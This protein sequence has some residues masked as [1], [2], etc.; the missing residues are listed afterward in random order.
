MLKK[1]CSECRG[2]W[3]HLSRCPLLQRAIRPVCP[4]CGRASNVTIAGED[5]QVYEVTCEVC[6]LP[7]FVEVH[8]QPS[9]SSRLT[10]EPE[11]F[12]F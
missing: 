6:R 3:K 11:D 2:I 5:K 4:C 1:R 8:L 10:R 9:F 7:F 12:A